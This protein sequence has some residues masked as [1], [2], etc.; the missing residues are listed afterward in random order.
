MVT[1]EQYIEDLN[2]EEDW[3]LQQNNIIGLAGAT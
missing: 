2:S 1:V 3:K